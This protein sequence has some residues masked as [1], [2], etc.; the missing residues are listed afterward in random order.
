MREGPARW[1]EP[2]EAQS[3]GHQDVGQEF[4]MRH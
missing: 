3:H 1:G 2:E 4:T